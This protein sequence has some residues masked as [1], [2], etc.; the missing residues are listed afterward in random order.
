MRLEEEIQQ[1]K[2]RNEYHKLAVNLLYTHGWLLNQQA[3]F[4]KKNKITPAQ[5]NI[6]R[7]LRGQYPEAASIN[8][9]KER[10]LDKMSDASRLV[11][12]LKIKKLVKREVCPDDRRKVEVVIT[13][14]GLQLLEKMS[15]LEEHFDFMLKN[16]NLNEAKLLNDLLDKMRAQREIKK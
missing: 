8:L 6:L 1:K 12:R 14:S 3:T 2:F 5:F 4:F 15:E 11:D 13:K 16:L 7:I 9:L 10:M